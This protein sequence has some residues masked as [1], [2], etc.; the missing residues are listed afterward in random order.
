MLIA[1]LSDPHIRP[2]GKLYKDQIESNRMF[3]DA[4]AH[5]HGLDRRPDLVVLSGDLVDRGQADEYAMVRELLAGLAIPWL[6]MPGNHDER[7]QFRA[8]FADQPYLPAN[9][10]LHYVV[11]DYPVRIVALDSCPPGRHDGEID[12]AGLHWLRATLTAE[13]AKPT[14]VLL[15]HPP[16]VS[17]IPYMDPYRYVDAE[18]LAAVIRGFANIEAVLCG[19][20]HRPMAK[21]WAGT[22]VLACP[23]TATE[24]ALQLQPEATPQSFLGP[25]ACLLHLWHPA[26]GLVSHTSYIGSYPG[27]YPFI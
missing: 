4:I 10:P 27:P 23:S 2:K 25:P 8:A 11:D 5:L 21:R 9:G 14:L 16:F 1:Q 20:V 15:H 22:V 12:A 26:H 19:H 3:A 13:P 18:P 17:G 24:I 7:E 6:V